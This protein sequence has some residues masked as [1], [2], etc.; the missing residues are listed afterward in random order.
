MLNDKMNT[1]IRDVNSHLAEREELVHTIAL[2][3]LTGKNL[4]VLGKPGQAK[5]YAIDLFRSHI[6]GAKQFDVL[7]SKG[8]DQEQLFGRLDLASIIPGHLSHSVLRQDPEYQRLSSELQQALDRADNT[9]SEQIRQAMEERRLCLAELH[10]GEPEIMTKNKIPDSH[11]CFLDEI[12]KSNDGVLN[13]L[14]KALNERTYTNEGVTVTIPVI[15]FF[16]ASNEIPNF[17]NAEEKSLEALYDRFDFKLITHNV[18]DKSNRMAILHQ[19]QHTMQNTPA[20][21]SVTLEELRDMQCEVRKVIVPDSINELADNILCELRRRDIPVSDRTYFGFAP[22]VQAEAW[23]CGRDTVLP[24]DMIALQNY[25]WNRPEEY[26]T[27]GEVIQ[28]LAD[29]PMK[30]ALDNLRAQVYQQRNAFD[31]ET[32]KNRALFGFRNGLLEIYEKAE[33]L[34]TD[35]SEDNPA[36]SAIDGFLSDMEEVS[37]EVHAN[38]KFTYIPMAELKAMQN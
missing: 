3:L 26:A 1:V 32:D 21:V 18:A 38:T 16:S 5:S 37:K 36:M 19:K 31:K 10:G 33:A 11:I 24:E 27:V 13:S 15:S 12:F 9:A 20:S 2:A 35:L 8:T 29:N 25:L 30:K 6:A 4:F 23:L 28:R 14:L 22:I 34:R 7:M 17:N